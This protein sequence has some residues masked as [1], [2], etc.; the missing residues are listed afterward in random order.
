M[1]TVFVPYVLLPEV[2]GLNVNSNEEDDER[3]RLESGSDERTVI[4]CVEVENSGDSGA[5]VGFAV[6]QVN[7]KIGG[8]GAKATLIS[9]GN[10]PS[11]RSGQ[12]PFPLYLGSRA[13]YNLLYAVTFL[14][15]PDDV[16]GFSLTRDPATGERYVGSINTDL[17]RAVTINILG[18]PYHQNSKE[19]IIDP[20]KI[21]TSD[22]NS[23][24][25]PTQT[26]SSRWNCVLDLS[27][28]QNQNTQILDDNHETVPGRPNILPEPASPFPAAAPKTTAL[29]SPAASGLSNGPATAI[30]GPQ[31]IAMAG[32]RHTL[33]G[34]SVL[35][36][37]AVKGP[38]APHRAS[39]SMLNPANAAARERERD[40]ATGQQ[41]SRSYLP[42]S[43]G[44][45]PPR[46][47]TTYG[48]PP[49][50][51]GVPPEMAEPISR[52][53]SVSPGANI[54]PEFMPPPT[55]AY[56]A[57]PQQYMVPPTPMGQGPIST[58][59]YA[60]VGP[61][62]E[63]RRERG[64]GLGTEGTLAPPTPGPSIHGG[65]GEQNIMKD[66]KYAEES[67]ESVVVSVG[68]VL[69]GSRPFRFKTG[70]QAQH[71][72]TSSSPSPG[73]S[74]ESTTVTREN[75]SATAAPGKRAS[76][77]IYPMDYFWLDVFVF[78]Q[79]M[80]P[81]RF[82]ITCPDKRRGRGGRARQGHD[83]GFAYGSSA[84][85]AQGGIDFKKIEY[86]GVLPLDYRIRIG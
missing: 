11:G 86:P 79:S 47:P 5:N 44:V 10:G 60:K 4:L 32:K 68:L 46:T 26:F 51:S 7:V 12:N 39:T 59:T 14:R 50:L 57:Y 38:V 34:S 17:Q 48:P 15:S 77:K 30:P 23:F 72:T 61:S 41:T 9:W 18:K 53:G 35:A 28:H 56:P 75:G 31:Q 65:F 27:S 81:R 22:T 37:R 73:L 80:W 62:V 85:G 82:E 2:E 29:F 25:F 13:Q 70:S 16:D 3:E 52:R 54:P 74:S 78:N 83:V 33:P 19:S 6:E 40:V 1:R 67:G 24:S 71:E 43:I 76:G 8:E 36:N 84:H 63:I 64:M 55:P 66:L 49:P 20:V 21:L 42:P 58:H 45:Q 69:P